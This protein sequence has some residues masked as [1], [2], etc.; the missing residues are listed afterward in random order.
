LLLMA[1]LPWPTWERLILW[2]AIGMEVYFGYAIYHSKLSP[3][4]PPGETSWSRALKLIA[5]TWIVFGALASILWMFRYQNLVYSP[6]QPL[7][8]LW[9][10]L[11]LLGSVSIGVL[12][13]VIA[14]LAEH[15]HARTGE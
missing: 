11:G 15:I 14:N 8:W 10:I 12:L 9:G 7:G 5:V 1:S 4:A 13:H 6:G 2:F 3:G